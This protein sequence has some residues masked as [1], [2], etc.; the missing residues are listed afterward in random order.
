[1]TYVF[2]NQSIEIK[3]VNALY[4]EFTLPTCQS[5][6]HPLKL[7]PLIYKMFAFHAGFQVS[8]KYFHDLCFG[9]PCG[10]FFTT[11]MQKKFALIRE[12]LKKDLANQN[13]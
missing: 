8:T 12:T 9:Y 11:F 7:P 3:L 5:K 4:A 13:L 1:M 10:N 6:K 2:A